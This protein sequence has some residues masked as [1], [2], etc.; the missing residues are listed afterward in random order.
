MD[1]ALLYPMISLK[2]ENVRQIKSAILYWDTIKTIIPKSISNP[3]VSNDEK[4]LVD[5]GILEPHFVDSYSQEVLTASCLFYERIKTKEFLQLLHKTSSTGVRN[6]SHN[7]FTIKLRDEGVSKSP[8]Y[9]DKFYLSI[10]KDLRDIGIEIEKKDGMVELPTPLAVAYLTILSNTIAEKNKYDCLTWD[11][12]AEDLLVASR[13]GVNDTE[14]MYRWRDDNYQT[15]RYIQGLTAILS[16]EAVNISPDVSVNK[17]IKYKS[18]YKDELK[19]YRSNL[20]RIVHV[21][22]EISLEEMYHTAKS[23]YQDEIAPSL[24]DIKKSLTGLRIKWFA[25]GALKLIMLSVGSVS[26]MP[27]L[28]TPMP[29]AL[30]AGLGVSLVTNRIQYHYEREQMIKSVPYSYLIRLGHLK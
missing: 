14:Q 25:D 7:K 21:S 18:R 12:A 16:I 20:K 22:D 6:G 2:K 3:Y 17:L 24:S 4:V 19:R 1:T 5:S 13:C 8:L 15:N 30:L 28:G 11:Y 29:I 26:L 9:L 27:A 10:L 23:I